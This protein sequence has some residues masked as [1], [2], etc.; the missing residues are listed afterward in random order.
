MTQFNHYQIRFLDKSNE[1]LSQEE[2]EDVMNQTGFLKFTRGHFLDYI[3]EVELIIQVIIENYM[4][5]KKSKLKGVF[6]TNVLN[7]MSLSQKIEVLLAIINEKK[8]L[9]NNDLKLLRGYSG[10]LRKERNK[11][12]H[13]ILHFKQEK[14]GKI[15]KFQS[16]LNWI[17]H[18]GEEKETKLTNAYFD[19]L[20][21][22][23]T[24]NRD[25]LVRILV[26]RGFLSKDYLY[27]E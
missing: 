17:N 5:H 2:Y 27:K 13:G 4:L 15:I 25:F 6:R 19:D 12:A 16:Y 8:E 21:N 18:N 10:S 9:N 26:K 11:W 1:K 23:F 20:T 3:L 24:T 22:K 7:K 14:H